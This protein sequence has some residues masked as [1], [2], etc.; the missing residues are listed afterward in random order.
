MF[1]QFM[2]VLAG[3]GEGHPV[4]LQQGGTPSVMPDTLLSMI[5]HRI[6]SRIDVSGI[7]EG[8]SLWARDWLN[9]V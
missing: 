2:P 7:I 9:N 1:G 3:Q 6:A 8:R 5:A 4:P